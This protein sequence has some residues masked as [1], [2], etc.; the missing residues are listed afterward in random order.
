VDLVDR[1]KKEQPVINS[2]RQL[3]GL[4]VDKD[5][6][7]AL[8]RLEQM[9]LEHL[10]LIDAILTLPKTSLE[11]KNRRRIAAINAITAYYSVEEGLPSRRIRR[12]R[13]LKN[14]SPPAVKAEE[15]NALSQ[16]IRSIK[17]EKRPT[18][19]CMSWEPIS[20]VA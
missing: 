15:P 16:A 17:I 13:P 18:M 20:G 14:N 8:D 2:K 3:V 1:Y 4:V 12:G 19:F 5:T 9:T 6:L 11:N 7:E 10:L